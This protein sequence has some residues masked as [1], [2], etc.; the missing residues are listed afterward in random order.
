MNKR[1]FLSALVLTIVGV[2]LNYPFAAAQK[3]RIAPCVKANPSYNLPFY[4]AEERNIWKKNGIDG[5]WVGI[6]GGAAMARA[7]AAG[8]LDMGICGPLGGIRAIARGVP[9]VIIA[10]YQSPQVWYIFV[11]GDSRIKGPKDLKGARIGVSRL[12]GTAHAYGMVIAKSLG[13]EKDISWQGAGGTQEQIAT[14]KAGVNDGMIASFYTMVA[15][16]F[17]GGG[18]RG[19]Q[20]PRLPSQGMDGL[21]CIRPQ[22]VCGGEA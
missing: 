1:I 6:K 17:K 15:L 21:G 13:L 19:G 3:V 12:G 11:R 7:M 16:K 8:A 22:R 20:D 10:D 18:A 14:L 4:A 9:E 5:E 2:M